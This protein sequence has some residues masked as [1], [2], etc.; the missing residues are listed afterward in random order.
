MTQLLIPASNVAR[1]A[2]PRNAGSKETQQTTPPTTAEPQGKKDTERSPEPFERILSRKQ[3][4]RPRA[5][6]APS[7]RTPTVREGT[8][9]ASTSEYAN[10]DEADESPVATTGI[11]Q[12]SPTDNAPTTGTPTATKGV[13]PTPIIPAEPIAA[14]ESPV[15]PGLVPSVP[16]PTPANAQP[17]IFPETSSTHAPSPQSAAPQS[18]ATLAAQPESQPQ[19]VATPTPQA[20]ATQ[21]PTQPPPPR[22]GPNKPV[23]ST[24]PST[25]AEH[26]ADG[27]ADPTAE[28]TAPVATKQSAPSA[29]ASPAPSPTNQT[30]PQ[31]AAHAPTRNTDS[32]FRIESA[33]QSPEPSLPTE[34]APRST[35]T[36][37]PTIARPTLST[38][39]QPEEPPPAPQIVSRGLNAALA[40]RGGVVHIRLV[41]E[42]L[43]EVRINMT[44]DAASVNVRIDAATPAA[45]RLL[46]DHLGTLRASL[47]ARGIQVDRIAVNLTPAIAN[48]TP[49]NQQHTS[50]DLGQSNSQNSNHD[51][52]GSQSR[53]RSNDNAHNPNHNPAELDDAYA[54]QNS[55][56]NF[57]SRL[58]LRLSTVA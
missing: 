16:S 24:Q 32:I 41:P 12:P 3:N 52:A 42:S 39:P 57:D 11:E 33:P 14:P 10:A 35:P 58:R 13:L 28:E 26:A 27:P 54:P 31:S 49:Q 1:G 56:T 19:S 7:K 21:L 34:P 38:A 20:A 25:D 6:D 29:T 47:E 48:S 46:T 8:D 40:Q 23:A 9:S 53:G 55:P 2:T 44:L 30:P 51:A 50:A 36:D 15:I 37:T 17:S 18:S 4:P 22:S 5:D 45:Q 43:G